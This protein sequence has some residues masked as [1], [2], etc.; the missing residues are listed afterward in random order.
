LIKILWSQQL[1][2]E[3]TERQRQEVADAARLAEHKRLSALLSTCIG[4]GN[5]KGKMTLFDE[6]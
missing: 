4:S 3:E 2:D 5:K 1:A 6:I